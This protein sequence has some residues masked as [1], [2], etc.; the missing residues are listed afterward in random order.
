[1]LG[2]DVSMHKFVEHVVVIPTRPISLKTESGCSSFGQFCNGVSLSFRVAGI[3]EV[4]TGNFRPPVSDWKFLM[5]FSFFEP[6][7]CSSL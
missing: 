3:S 2:Y 6:K 1:L 7:W 5:F 4:L